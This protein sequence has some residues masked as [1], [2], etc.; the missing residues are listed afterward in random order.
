M[1][2]AISL[3]ALQQGDTQAGTPIAS[4]NA[5]YTCNF[6]TVYNLE[7]GTHLNV[8]SGAGANFSRL[9]QLTNG[10]SVYIC[11]ERG[12]WLKVYY[13]GLDGPCGAES[14]QGLD[15]RK[16]AACKSGWVRRDWINVLSG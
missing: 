14:P 11:D 10:A 3:I 15:V 6:A 12:E 5:P 1:V 8:R 16:A 7:D 4:Y 9:D 13:S 2:L